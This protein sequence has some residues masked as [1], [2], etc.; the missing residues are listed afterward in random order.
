LVYTET[1]SVT[2]E[3]GKSLEVINGEITIEEARLGKIWKRCAAYILDILIVNLFIL[4]ILIAVTLVTGPVVEV[5]SIA[6]A[7]IALFAYFVYFESSR[8]QATPG[9]KW[10][11]LKVVDFEERRISFRRAF[12]R[13][14]ARGMPGIVLVVVDVAA[15]GTGIINEHIGWYFL[16]PFVTYAPVL[17]MDMKQGVHDVLA[18]TVVVKSAA[19]DTK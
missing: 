5:Y 10:M 3:S 6:F 14:F 1:V 15:N 17:F 2:C 18:G 19:D 8:A 11:N 12:F 4:L 9:K 16:I 13:Y 7:N